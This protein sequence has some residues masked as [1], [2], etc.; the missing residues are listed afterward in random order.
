M[1][2]PVT[3][4]AF[5]RT[6]AFAPGLVPARSVHGEQR[7][8]VVDALMRL[9][10]GRDAGW[11]ATPWSEEEKKDD[12]ASSAFRELRAMFPTEPFEFAMVQIYMNGI[13]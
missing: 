12:A 11:H 4:D 13:L 2:S 6:K 5:V 3:S 8:T 1:P 9:F 10:R 7:K